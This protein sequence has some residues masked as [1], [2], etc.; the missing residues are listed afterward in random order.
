VSNEATLR[1][2][3]LAL[4]KI[5]RDHHVFIGILQQN[6]SFQKEAT[7]AAEP[8]KAGLETL[9]LLEAK[10]EKIGATHHAQLQQ[11]VE[12][13]DENTRLLDD[14]IQRLRSSI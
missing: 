12:S 9:E 5:T 11:L 2:A 14:L 6:L 8:A 13:G 7:E 3:V 1:E 10:L 4:L